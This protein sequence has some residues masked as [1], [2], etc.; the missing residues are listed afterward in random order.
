MTVIYELTFCSESYADN[1]SL[2]NQCGSGKQP[3]MNSQ[4]S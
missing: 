3:I 2:R 1:V 4:N